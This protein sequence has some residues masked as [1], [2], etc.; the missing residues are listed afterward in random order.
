MEISTSASTDE[1][2]QVRQPRQ[3][4][5]RA[6]DRVLDGRASELHLFDPAG[7]K[8]EQLGQHQLRL[9]AGNANGEPDHAAWLPSARRSLANIDS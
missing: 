6:V 2:V 4:T 1:R 9:L 7:R 5:G 8:L 3:L